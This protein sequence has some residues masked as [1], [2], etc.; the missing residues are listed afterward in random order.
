LGDWLKDRQARRPSGA[1]S[2]A[3]YADP[4]Y[5]YPN[6]KVILE[7]L[8]LT[9]DDHLVEVGCGGG[10][11]LK[12]AL[13]SGCRA[14]AVD[15]SPDMVRL[16]RALNAEAVAAGRLEIVEASAERL[17]FPDAAFTCA[18]MTGVLGFLT[19][20]V[21]ALSELRRVLAPGG[22]CLLQ[23]PLDLSRARTYE[24]PAITTPEARLAAYWQ[25]DHVRLFGRDA[26]DRVAA[27]GFSVEVVKPREAFGDAVADRAVLLDGDWLLLCR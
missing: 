5:H 25:P 18:C 3:T 22:W 6:F 8:A 19:D 14:A 15:H 10:A 17:P 12:Q 26:P 9:P 20:P 24:D 21:T 11:L 1:R 27:G 4:L 23:F 7:E 2:R 13:A 16:A